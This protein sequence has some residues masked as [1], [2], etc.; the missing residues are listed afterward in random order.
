MTISHNR[1]FKKMFKKHPFWVRKKLAERSFLFLQDQY[2]PLL[3]NHTLGG[4]WAGHRSINITGDIRVI[5][6]QIS[7]D[8]VVFVAIGSHSELYS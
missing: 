6:R 2:N 7:D 5:F 8:Y 4:E 1:G 3:N